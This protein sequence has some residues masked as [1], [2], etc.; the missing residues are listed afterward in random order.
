MRGRSREHASTWWEQSGQWSTAIYERSQH[1]TRKNDIS[2]FRVEKV[3]PNHQVIGIGA[4][5]YLV[6]NLL[7][8]GPP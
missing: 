6:S 4:R 7:V 5:G 2:H 3:A 8:S 1:Q